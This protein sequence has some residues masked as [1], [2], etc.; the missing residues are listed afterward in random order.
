MKKEIKDEQ[1]REVSD[2]K[3]ISRG[4]SSAQILKG[5]NRKRERKLKCPLQISNSYEACS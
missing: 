5:K 1:L 4:R 3:T 2:T